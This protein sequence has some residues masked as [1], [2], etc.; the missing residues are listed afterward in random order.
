M[1]I[2]NDIHSCGIEM[3]QYQ[4]SYLETG[5]ILYFG[6]WVEQYERQTT[7]RHY[8]N[9][10]LES[11]LESTRAFIELKS[12]HTQVLVQLNKPG[13]II[14][15]RNVEQQLQLLWTASSIFVC[16]QDVKDSAM[17]SLATRYNDT[18]PNPFIG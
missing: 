9:R 3:Y 18:Q 7:M 4:Y 11:I 12:H 17:D 13:T 2:L 6:C 1:N 8:A 14:V 10:A 16:G 15:L 5:T